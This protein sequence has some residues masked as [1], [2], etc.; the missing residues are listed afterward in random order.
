MIQI[1]MDIWLRY[2]SDTMQRKVLSESV[3]SS[4]SD[5]ATRRKKI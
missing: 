1:V 2:Y 4:C 5:L 3:L